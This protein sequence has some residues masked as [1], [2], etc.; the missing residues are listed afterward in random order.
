MYNIHIIPKIGSMTHIQNWDIQ[1][2]WLFFFVQGKESSFT[3]QAVYCRRI[4][5]NSTTKY[6]II[7]ADNAN[8]LLWSTK[9]LT[10]SVEEG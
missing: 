4:S 5:S 1:I 7:C 3:D 9:P 8:G 10:L 2:T 6:N